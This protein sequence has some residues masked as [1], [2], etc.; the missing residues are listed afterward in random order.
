MKSNQSSCLRWARVA[1]F[2]CIALLGAAHH[3]NAQ[4]FVGLEG[5][6]PVTRSSDLSGFPNVTWIDHFAFDVSGAAASPDGTLYL[7]NGA[8]TT[9]L[10]SSTLNGPPT[11]RCTIDKDMSALAYGRGNLY[12]YSNYADPK[13]IYQIDVNTGVTTLVLDVYTNTGFRYFA[14]DYNPV[15]DLFYG[16]TEYGDSG[17]YAINIDTGT[18]T[19]I[20][21]PI[22]ASNSQGRGLAVG[23]NTVYVTATRGD[24]NIPHYAYDL[25]QGPNGS[26]VP[27]TQS[28][29]AYH[30]T[31]GAA[32]IARAGY[33]IGLG[34]A[35]DC[36]GRLD[37]RATGAT[38][39]GRV[40]FIYARGTGGV[41]I[42]NGPCAGTQLG[43]NASALLAATVNADSNGT[44]ILS[45]NAGANACGG[46]IVLQA[47]DLTT[48][49]PSNVVATP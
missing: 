23:R 7:C 6:E 39:G 41:R 24:D 35:G 27:F 30:S 14:L 17:L 29:P 25:S 16:Y 11:L 32:Y 8:F 19:K 2:L 33:D 9:K 38:H 46:A 3:A 48:C 45:R 44:A 18:Q 26:W 22:P 49:T 42:P 4:L 10:Y 12:G 31:G 5:G 34:L 43:L 21:G 28:Y 40:A 15:D 20:A 36:P 13:G 37:A 47:L 1:S